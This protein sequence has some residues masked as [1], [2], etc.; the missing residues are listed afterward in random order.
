MLDLRNFATPEQ[1]KDGASVMVRAVR[2]DDKGRIIAAF[3]ELEPETIYT[4][5]FQYKSE[6][7]NEELQRATEVDFE[8][9]VALVVTIGQGEQETIIGGA[10]YVVYEAGAT[11][12][13]EIAFTVEEDY[14]GQ[15]IASSLLR[16]LIQIARAKGV[17]RLEAEVLA[18][19]RS[20]L[21]VFSR[22]GLPMKMERLDD[23]MHVTLTLGEI[24][25]P[26][27]P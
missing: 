17:A 6:L 23:V 1:L 24:A 13:A 9:T 14:Q 16:H 21:A 5:Y 25:P 26:N 12:S 27:T 11:R 7:T 18:S 4:R 10:R 3:R 15:G 20:M 19:N 8:N 22:C 2:P